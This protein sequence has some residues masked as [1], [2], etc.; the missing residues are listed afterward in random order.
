MLITR[1]Q[2]TN[3]RKLTIDLKSKVCSSNHTQHLGIYRA[4]RR[5]D[6]TLFWVINQNAS[7]HNIKKNWHAPAIVWGFM[8][9]AFS[10]VLYL[11]NL[12]AEKKYHLVQ[13]DI[14]NI[15]H[16]A[17]S[18]LLGGFLTYTLTLNYYYLDSHKKLLT[19]VW[20][21]LAMCLVAFLL[22]YVCH[23]IC[24]KTTVYVSFYNWKNFGCIQDFFVLFALCLNKCNGVFFYQSSKCEICGVHNKSQSFQAGQFNFFGEHQFNSSNN[25]NNS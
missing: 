15:R 22:R 5:K 8:S 18:A 24:Y 12:I 10:T 2:Q 14:W 1:Y 21:T 11:S 23:S 13:T 20:R 6:N 25:I 7:N 19:H 16:F 17:C 9:V 3:S 4:K